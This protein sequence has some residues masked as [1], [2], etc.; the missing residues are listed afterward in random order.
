LPGCSHLPLPHFSNYGDFATIKTDM[1]A[2]EL[3][4]GDWVYKTEESLKRGIYYSAHQIQSQDF[5]NDG[6]FDMCHPIPL[7]AEILEKNPKVYYLCSLHLNTEESAVNGFA[8]K[9][10]ANCIMGINSVHE[11]QHAL[12]LFGLNDLADNFKV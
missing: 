10:G 4:I 1:K 9:V 5:I 6:F 2:T 8:L 11:L 12:R 7:T 3:M